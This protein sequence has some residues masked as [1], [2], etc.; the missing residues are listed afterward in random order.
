M[1]KPV[2]DLVNKL[3]K[4]NKQ[5]KIR[6]TIFSRVVTITSITLIV[7]FIILN[8]V[9]RTVYSNFF[10]ITLRQNG[11]NISSIVEGSLYYSMLENDK[12]MLQR[13]I[14]VIST[15]SGIDEANMYDH[16]D[17]LAYTSVNKYGESVCNPD[18]KQ[19]HDN[20]DEMFDPKNKS[21]RIV[22]RKHNCQEGQYSGSERHLII[23]KPILNEKSCFTAACHF[24][25]KDDE[26]L[27]SLILKLPLE[28]LDAFVNRS[29]TNFL[30]LA[31]IITLLLVTIL[32]IFTRKKIKDPLN[33]IILASEAVSKGDN[34][35]R[36]EIKSNLLDDLR[37]VSLAFNNMLYNIE[38]SSKELQ[39]WSQQ[40][41]YKVQKKTEELSEA[42]NELIH[43]ER[44]ASLGKLS[45]SV[46]HEINNPLSGIFIY[47]KLIYK[48]LDN[49]DFYHPKKESILKNL[50]FIETETKRCGDIVKG[51]LDFSR[52]DQ[53]GFIIADLHEILESTYNLMSH[54]IKM[55][56]ISF[57]K[58]LKAKVS[59]V[60]CS[61]NQI[62]QAGV[63]LIVNASEAIIENGEI[64][65]KTFNPTEN[66]IK[67]E[68]VDN[69]KGISPDD[70]SH[71]FE[72]FFS[73]KHDASGIGLGLSIV[74][75]IVENH[76]G[77]IGVESQPGAGTSIAITFT[78]KKN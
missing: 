14:D 58:E 5:Y 45:S 31:T 74:H 54:P 16:R 65:I 76:K 37:K 39:N 1:P 41:E 23:R 64:I 18:C 26:V 50:K 34:D 17:S 78:T 48:Q 62:K 38:S 53:E 43:V 77:N 60:F 59:Q 22:D 9:F 56:D 75:G 35:M 51:L 66:T 2:I 71:I 40:L 24:H 33:S 68:I 19:C 28:E 12:A 30:I 8:I 25:D 72:P 55:K 3:F 63:A 6:S 69:G 20:L 36:I 73:T 44:I 32:I 49:S 7:L 11:D 46:A 21:Y 57:K 67:L 52:K 61:P 47:T 27:G 13:T 4:R 70:L 15:M 42:H 29:S 10:N